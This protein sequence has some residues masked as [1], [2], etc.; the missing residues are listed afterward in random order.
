MRTLNSLKLKKHQAWRKALIFPQFHNMKHFKWDNLPNVCGC[1]LCPT[2]SF[3]SLFSLS[4]G[5]C[6]TW[7]AMAKAARSWLSA[8][9]MTFVIEGS[10]EP[11]QLVPMM[12]FRSQTASNNYETKARDKWDIWQTQRKKYTTRSRC[13]QHILFNAGQKAWNAVKTFTSMHCLIQKWLPI[14]SQFW[15]QQM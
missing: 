14:A 12:V 15:E 6:L 2:S 8:R 7:V 11:W 3:V 4:R 13:K 1:L 10:M 5:S 9:L